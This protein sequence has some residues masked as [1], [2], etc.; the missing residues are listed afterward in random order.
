MARYN[1]EIGLVLCFFFLMLTF[2]S[3]VDPHTLPKG[4]ACGAW[5]NVLKTHHHS[6]LGAPAKASFVGGQSSLCLAART[7][8][9]LEVNSVRKGQAKTA[10]QTL[11]LVGTLG[12]G[13]KQIPAHFPSCEATPAD[14]SV[15][16]PSRA[17]W[18][19]GHDFQPS[20]PSLQ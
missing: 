16:A 17:R 9:P 6:Q 19:S 10:V 4:G 5:G 18:G 11:S 12:Q 13:P 14:L 8:L 2:P 20:L 15:H 7:Y 3:S 1:L